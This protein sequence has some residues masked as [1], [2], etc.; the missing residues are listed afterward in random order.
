[1]P[2][3]FFVIFFGVKKG[4]IFMAGFFSLCSH[5]HIHILWY[6]F[7]TFLLFWLFCN[8]EIHFITVFTPAIKGWERGEERKWKGSWRLMQEG[9]I[10]CST[11][12]TVV[13]FVS[14]CILN[15][16]ILFMFLHNVSFIAKSL[17]FCES[18]T[19]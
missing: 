9:S 10:L 18:F 11:Y 16:L 17:F 1:M 7:N 12:F 2:V 5:T 4:Y 3:V 14:R 19:I 6:L 8:I 15:G 13:K